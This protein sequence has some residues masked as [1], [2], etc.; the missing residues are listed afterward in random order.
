MANQVS[1]DVIKQHL[2]ENLQ[3]RLD[4]ATKNF[5]S[6]TTWI[7]IAHHTILAILWYI[8]LLWV[9]LEQ[10]LDDMENMVIGFLI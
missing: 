1:L 3:K 5:A 2:F 9:D 7:T 10:D 4:K 6:L 8:L